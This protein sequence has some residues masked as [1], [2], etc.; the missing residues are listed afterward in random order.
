MNVSFSVGVRQVPLSLSAAVMVEVNPVELVPSNV[1]VGRQ[2]DSD[3]S[4]RYDLPINYRG[5]VGVVGRGRL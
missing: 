3:H 4:R 2:F 1:P 5:S